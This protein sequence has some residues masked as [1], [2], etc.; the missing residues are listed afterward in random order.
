M[1][2]PTY[3]RGLAAHMRNAE[4]PTRPK[5][6]PHRFARAVMTLALWCAL[7]AAAGFGAA[8]TLAHGL[9]AVLL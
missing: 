4:P 1:T 8:W 6:R 3:L 5:P 9:R 2:A 7:A